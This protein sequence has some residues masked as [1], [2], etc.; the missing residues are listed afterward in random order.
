MPSFECWLS[1]VLSENFVLHSLFNFIWP[2]ARWA[3]KHI[4]PPSH[5]HIQ[6]S[7]P[8]SQNW[9]RW[10][11]FIGNTCKYLVSTHSIHWPIRCTETGL[12]FYNNNTYLWTL[13][14]QTYSV[15][16]QWAHTPLSGSLMKLVLWPLIYTRKHEH[17]GRL[18]QV[19]SS[20]NRKKLPGEPTWTQRGQHEGVENNK[21]C[22]KGTDF[23]CTVYNISSLRTM[24]TMRTIWGPTVH[25]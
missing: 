12:S 14:L 11:L 17:S 2:H 25:E 23:F 1:F 18:S 3:A 21:G 15:T 19:C 13:T 20:F 16:L 6:F 22:V 4:H 9:Q 5:T 8:F 24:K 7:L 10:P